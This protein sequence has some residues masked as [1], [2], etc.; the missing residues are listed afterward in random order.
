MKYALLFEAG[1]SLMAV[2]VRRIRQILRKKNIT[3]LPQ[4]PEYLE[5]VVVYRDK[6]IPVV[7]IAKKMNLKETNSKERIILAIIDS[8]EIGFKVDKVLE[9]IDVSKSK[10]KEHSDKGLIE[11]TITYQDNKIVV[12]IDPNLLFNEEE[13]EIL[14]RIQ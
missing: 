3:P 1:N 6:I 5:G 8:L 13:R 11:G 7:N 14:E 4:S 9:V 2:N 12:V 10:I